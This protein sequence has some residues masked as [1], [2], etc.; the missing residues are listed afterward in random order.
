MKSKYHP[1]LFCTLAASSA[2][3]CMAS[4]HAATYEWTGAG[5]DI[6]SPTALTGE[7]LG[8]NGMIMR[9][10]GLQPPAP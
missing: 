4:A 9:F 3:L 6:T 1:F 10:P 5:T 2:I 8:P 7:A